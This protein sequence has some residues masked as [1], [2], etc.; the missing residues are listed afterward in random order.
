MSGCATPD[1]DMPEPTARDLA[2]ARQEL[3]QA[4]L[5]PVPKAI[6][7]HVDAI[8][9]T[10]VRIQEAVLRIC[11]RL[12]IG[13]CDTVLNSP[14]Q[15]VH[16]PGTINASANSRD[17]V[18]VYTGLIDRLGVDAELAG[19]LAHEYA[20]VMLGHV[21]KTQTNIL[22][23]GVLL[24]G[25]V[26]GVAALNGVTLD[27]GVYTDMAELGMKLGRV[28]YSPAMELEADRLGLYILSE[29][30]YRVTAMRDALIR[31]S[32]VRGRTPVSFFAT[33]PSDD[34][35]I[36]HVLTAMYDV[37]AGRPLKMKSSRVVEEDDCSEDWQDCVPT[38]N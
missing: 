8:S 13:V 35:R 12:Q 37:V 25:L 32:R 18:T 24:S 27:P 19:V 5:A 29:A 23:G 26:G 20:H 9:P 7:N 38:Q 2:M 10:A 33:H 28:A 17:Q 6:A 31:L 34:R 36:A 21:A 16:D 14:V 4:Y 15:V 1:L 22:T 11:P 30:G 3:A